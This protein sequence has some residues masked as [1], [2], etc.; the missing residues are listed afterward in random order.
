MH[1]SYF[2]FLTYPLIHLCDFSEPLE[3][4]FAKI[5]CTCDKFV[6]V[7][8]D[9]AFRRYQFIGAIHYRVLRKGG[10]FTGESGA[11]INTKDAQKRAREGG[12]EGGGPRIFL[13]RGPRRYCS[14]WRVHGG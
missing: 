6:S 7:R 14:G 12:T 13:H 1:L 9:V 8:R 5:P 2:F 11:Q 3:L 4:N 10:E